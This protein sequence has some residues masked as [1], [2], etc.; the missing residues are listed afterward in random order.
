MSKLSTRRFA[1]ILLATEGSPSSQ[2]AYNV[3]AQMAKAF[4]SEVTILSAVP[5]MGVLAAPRKGEYD[6]TL[7]KKAE[8]TVEKAAAAL[9]TAGATVSGREVPR[10]L[11]SV[12]ET[13]VEYA[14]EKKIDLIVMG[15]RGLGGF[16]R[17]T[18]GSV[19]S[20]VASHA[21]CSTLV[22]RSN[23]AKNEAKAGIGRILVAIDGS[24]D[25]QRALETAVDMAKRL[26]AEL[27][28]AHVVFV[29]ALSWTLGL[30][31]LT[32]PTNEVEE[33]AEKAGRQLV[34]R[35]ARFAKESGVAKPKKET[36]TKLASPAQGIVEL[37]EKGGADVIVIGTR[38]LG[39]FKKMLMG[40]VANSVL[41]YANCSVLVAK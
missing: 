29:P 39:G 2:Q 22:V 28:I 14:A 41:R 37:A 18:L 23:K 5:S 15:T 7:V 12:V 40:S 9:Q 19:S 27:V 38:G 10:G 31:G 33:D 26:K 34:D 32:I 16:K 8:D 36:V 35:A 17:A 21:Q 25:A 4:D 3:A 6:T 24:Q 1:R 11:T 20:G 13:I 30:P